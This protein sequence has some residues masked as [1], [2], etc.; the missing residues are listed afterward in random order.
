MLTQE[1]GFLITSSYSPSIRYLNYHKFP[2]FTN[3]NWIFSIFELI[4]ISSFFH[5]LLLFDNEYDLLKSVMNGI[6]A[7]SKE[8]G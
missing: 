7:R 4:F 6:S 5:F 1:T 3:K 2:F 8:G